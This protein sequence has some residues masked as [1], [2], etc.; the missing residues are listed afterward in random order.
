[1]KGRRSPNVTN[2][3]SFIPST[4]QPFQVGYLQHPRH[5][6]AAD[7]GGT[8]LIGSKY[9]AVVSGGKEASWLVDHGKVLAKTRRDIGEPEFEQL[10]ARRERASARSAAGRSSFLPRCRGR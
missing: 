8:A 5:L 9:A 3:R 2:P 7:N 6:A 1:M 4:E 10:S